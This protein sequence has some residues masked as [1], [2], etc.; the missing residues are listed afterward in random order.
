MLQW[1]NLY[2]YDKSIYIVFWCPGTLC[3]YVMLLDLQ[4]PW[5]RLGRA[6]YC[7]LQGW[8]STICAA[9][10]HMNV[11]TYLCYEGLGIFNHYQTT[12]KQNTV[13][14]YCLAQIQG[15][16]YYFLVM[17]NI[18]HVIYF[19]IPVHILLCAK[20]THFCCHLIS[21]N[22]IYIYICIHHIHLIL[23]EQSTE[24]QA[25]INNYIPLFCR[26]HL[27]VSVPILLV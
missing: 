5:I 25:W 10:N 12:W 14:A 17:T 3:C 8:Y 11:N 4:Q 26:V 1:N 18:I 19:F 21:I 20:S 22:H 9:C 2:K 6:K 16:Y 13:W 23:T 7:P 15:K 24:I 27:T